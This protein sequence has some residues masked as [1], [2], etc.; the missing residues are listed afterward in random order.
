MA[1]NSEKG[2]GSTKRR[3][4]IG[5]NVALT[6]VIVAALI[7]FA[8]FLIGRMTPAPLDCTR[9]GQ[10]SLSSRTV[11]LLGEV[12][13]PVTLTALYRVRQEADEPLKQEDIEQKRRV[14]DLL[15]RYAKLS[16]HIT[17]QMIDPVSDTG[18][19]TALIKRLIEKYSGE[20]TQ[21][22]ELIGGFGEMASK[23]TKLFDQEQ[24]SLKQLI[25]KYPKLRDDRNILILLMQFNGGEE[26]T[27]TLVEELNELTGSADVPPYSEAARSIEQHYKDAKS[28]LEVGGQYFTNLASTLSDLSGD[29]L[30]FFA[31]AEARYRETIKQLDEKLKLCADLPKLELERIY[32]QIK[33]KMAKTILV[34]TKT[35]AKVLSFN[36]VWPRSQKAQFDEQSK[37]DFSGE[38]AVSSAILGLTAKEKSAVV[39]VHAGDPSPI[40]P[41][42]AQMRMVPPRYKAAKEKLEEVNFIVEDWD[43]RLKDT[44]PP[45]EKAKNRI[46]VI[47]PPPPPQQEQPGQ[48]PRNEGYEQKHLDIIKKLIDDGQRVI[49]LAHFSPIMMGPYPFTDTIVEKLG[50]KIEPDKLVIE[51]VRFK[52]Q[53]ALQ[54][55]G[56]AVRDYQHHPITEPIQSLNTTFGYPVPILVKDKLPEGV[57][58]SPLVQIGPEQGDRWAESNL[59]SLQK[60]IVDKDEYDTS[61]AFD[62]A[63]AVENTKTGAKAVVFGD[64]QFLTDELANRPGVVQVGRKYALVRANP[65]S[66]ELFTNSAFWLNDNQNMIAVGPRGDEVSR[67]K[68]MSEN[69]LLIWKIFLWAIWPLAVLAVGAAVHL[70]RRK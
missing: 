68:P 51:P 12:S 55:L 50:V 9:M 15:R 69:G 25:T 38:A 19:K 47:M 32:D 16:P 29:D 10:F 24:T 53:Y 34:E 44:P 65:G 26:N 2:T 36:D 52:N 45:I 6:L 7:V 42:F 28:T 22:K 35:A 18:P 58:V 62:L 20:A 39:F 54:S 27:R 57:K 13:E 33:P 4:L 40:K 43:I 8:N 60:G 23:T 31:G 11:K 66:L 37:Y 48:M 17:Y 5:G 1:I 21:H 49:F 41:S 3:L 70:V 14:E 63:V 64:D 30:A 46:Y 61:P 59:T 56:I 67:I